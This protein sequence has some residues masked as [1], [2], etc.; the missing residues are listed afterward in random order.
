MDFCVAIRGNS[1]YHRGM[2]TRWEGL[3]METWEI[4]LGI[5]ASIVAIIGFL[6]GC[7][8]WVYRKIAQWIA[9]KQEKPLECPTNFSKP[10][11]QYF[12]ERKAMQ[13][14]ISKTL[15]KKSPLALFGLG[16]MGKT[17]LA[18][19]YAYDHEKQY[20]CRWW[21]DASSGS[22]ITEAY[23]NF[24]VKNLGFEEKIKP[25]ECIEPVKE[26][27]RGHKNWLFVFDNADNFTRADREKYLPPDLTGRQHV[28]FTSRMRNWHGVA[29]P[30]EIDD[31]TL[32]E[33]QEFLTSATGKKDDGSQIDL[34]EALGHLPLGL[35]QAAAYIFVHGKS[36]KEY[37][38]LFNSHPADMLANYPGEEEDKRIV[39]KT[40]DISRKQIQRESSRELLN[41]L[42]FLSPDDICIEWFK[43][44]REVLPEALQ[45]EI[46][47]DRERDALLAELTKYSLVRFKD[48]KISIHRLVMTVV[49]NAL[50]REGKYAE[51]AGYVLQ[52]GEELCFFKFP[53]RESRVEFENLYPHIKAIVENTIPQNQNEQFALLCSFLGSGARDVWGAYD[54][55]LKWHEK[56]REI[57]EKAVGKEHPN[58][59]TTYDNIAAVYDRK[60]E[61][62]RALEWHEKAWDIRE[63]VLGKEHPSTAATYNNI[64][65]V[66]ASKG[67][68]DRALEWY[69]KAQA[70]NI[71]VLGQE[72]PHTLMTN[73]NIA[74]CKREMST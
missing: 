60:G 38:D 32:D 56:A 73:D 59:A 48:G 57:C 5:A 34:I 19:K 71:K 3:G 45:T 18:L 58:T 49:R 31:F 4:K 67:E 47:D 35:A 10:L 64:A 1:R 53:T 20:Q 22:S 27:M 68:Y 69:G 74:A 63:K 62:D 14:K 61:Y 39:Y 51:Y 8:S 12:T 43:Q 42:V 21:V 40:W 23:R 24:A 6:S 46:V 55:A 29:E 9:S 11:D 36:Y 37:I 13:K 28:L 33:A 7:F 30:L 25:E 65:G 15:S 44:T 16:G 50:T 2:S 66:H 52:F 54:L 17:Q 26:W 41:M 72:H 70:I